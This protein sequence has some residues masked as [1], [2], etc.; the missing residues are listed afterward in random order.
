MYKSSERNTHNK[1]HNEAASPASVP[2]DHNGKDPSSVYSNMPGNTPMKRGG[3]GVSSR[4]QNRNQLSTHIF[5]VNRN[6]NGKD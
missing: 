5:N 2:I 3:R 1:A 6:T 4:N